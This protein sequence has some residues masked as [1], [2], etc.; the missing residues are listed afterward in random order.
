[1]KKLLIKQTVLA[2]AALFVFAL[3][4]PIT[5]NAHSEHGEDTQ[6][7]EQNHKNIAQGNSA[8]KKE[9][10]KTKQA[11]TKLKACQKRKKKINNIMNHLA[12]RGTKQIDVFTKISERTQAF[13]IKKERHSTTT[14]LW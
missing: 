7:I 1:M 11:D 9:E 5:V 10:A 6:S 2:S 12:G 13:Y 8:D 4:A 14:M 3:A